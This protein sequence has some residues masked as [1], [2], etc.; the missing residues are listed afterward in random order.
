MAEIKA[1]FFD[2]DGVIIDTERDGHRV[3]FNR[4]FEQFGYDFFWDEA[5]YHQ[6]LQ[7]A[8][9]KERM[10]HYFRE[11]GLLSEFSDENLAQHL[12]ELHRCKTSIFLD[13]IAAGS[14]P[15]RPGISRFMGEAMERGLDI[16][17][18][19]TSTEKSAQT[20]VGTMLPEI[21]FAHILAGDIVMKKKPDPA[22]YNLALQRTGRSPD[23]CVVVEDSAIGVQAA[24][25]AGIRVIATTNGY[26][27]DEDL[28]A[29]DII[30]TTLGDEGVE[31]GVL[32]SPADGLDFDGVLHLAPVIR[33]FIQDPGNAGFS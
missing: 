17:L 16:C 30:V 13:M 29:A 18:C 33:Y 32:K 10:R 2:M 6:L 25:A 28:S 27:E 5:H 14:L 26:T 11:E 19:T 3:A 31:Y 12:I 1:L 7:V 24:K 20:V 4:A 22:I 15:L 21:E 8:G 9:G 23:E